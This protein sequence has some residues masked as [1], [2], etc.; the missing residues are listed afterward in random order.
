[1]TINLEKI[2]EAIF[3]GMVYLALAWVF[4][5]LSFQMYFVY[6]ELSGNE[7]KIYEVTNEITW[8]IDGRFK[9]NPNNIWYEGEK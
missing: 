4:F 1:M 6:L 3:S 2:K 9:N 5:A 8:R 7:K